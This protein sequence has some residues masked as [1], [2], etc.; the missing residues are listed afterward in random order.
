MAGPPSKPEPTEKQ[1]QDA[2]LEYLK[3]K[4]IF[5]WKQNVGAFLLTSNDK[6]RM[7]RSAFPGVS[8]ILGYLRDGRGLAI[9]VKRPGKKLTHDQQAFLDAVNA[10]KALGFVAHSGEVVAAKL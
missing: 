5:A 8:D 9:E 1:I 10:T 4:G 2:I 6:K 3:M 7:V